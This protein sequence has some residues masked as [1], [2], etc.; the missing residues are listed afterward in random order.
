M[1]S[2]FNKKLK[3]IYLDYSEPVS[4]AT[5]SLISIIL[6]YCDKSGLNKEILNKAFERLE[7]QLDCLVN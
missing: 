2:I 1:I 3:M 4:E 7:N 5:K 6:N